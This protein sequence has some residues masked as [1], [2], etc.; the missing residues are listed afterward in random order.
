MPLTEGAPR[1]LLEPNFYYTQEDLLTNYITTHPST[2]YNVTMPQWILSAVANTNMTIFYP[3]AV[4]AAVQQ[5]RKQPLRYPGSWESWDNNH[6]IITGTLLGRFYEWLVL[7]PETAGESFNITDGSEFT[8][9]R[10]WP[11]LAEWFGGLQWEP[12][13]DDATHYT[14]REMPFTPRGHGPRGKLRS[15]FSLVE[16]ARE[17][18]TRRAW[19][20]LR[21]EYG[22]SAE[23][24]EDPEGTFGFLQFALEVTWSWSTGMNKARRYGWLGHVDSV[25]SVRVVFGEMVGMGMLPRNPALASRA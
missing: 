12:P 21:E 22:L 1:V 17:P 11:I 18:E 7:H 10:L 5:K 3:L 23:P 4:Y 14:E 6:P 19:K 20:E 15:S 16:W 9:G 13:S 8:F 2:T 25:E 24:L